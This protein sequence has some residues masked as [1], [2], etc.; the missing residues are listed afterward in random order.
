MIPPGQGET[1]IPATRSDVWSSD[2]TSHN[3]EGLRGRKTGAELRSKE[4]IFLGDRK[5]ERFT[6]YSRDIKRYRQRRRR[7]ILTEQNIKSV[8]E[9][10]I[11]V[12][13]HSR[14]CSGGVA[15]GWRW[16]AAG[17]LY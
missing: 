17:V 8:N 6:T 2:G 5:Y 9:D 1:D 14:R 4:D 10:N 16:C 11:F 12:T 3:M 7:E 13:Y 15:L